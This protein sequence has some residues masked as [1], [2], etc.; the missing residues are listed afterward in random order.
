MAGYLLVDQEG[1]RD[2]AVTIGGED[3]CAGKT[4]KNGHVET[5]ISVDEKTRDQSGSRREGA[6]SYCFMRKLRRY[7]SGVLPAKPVSSKKKG[8]WLFLIL[9]IRSG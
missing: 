1:S 6:D 7:R 9:M 3:Y 4:N 2:I 5:I 8:L